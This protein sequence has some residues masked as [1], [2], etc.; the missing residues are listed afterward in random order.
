[1]SAGGV[2]SK[3]SGSAQSSGFTVSDAAST[4]SKVKASE[5]AAAAEGAKADGNFEFSAQTGGVDAGSA[6]ADGFSRKLI[7]HANVTMEVSDYSKAQTSVNNIIHLSGGYILQ[8][9]DQ[10]SASE[11]GGTYTIKIPASGFQTFLG[12]LEKLKHTQF[13]RSMKG[14]DVTEEYVDLDSRLKARKVVEARLLAFMDK[15]TRADDLLKFSNQL[16]DVQMEIE[17]IKGR[18]RYLDQNVAF[19]TIEL[20]LYQITGLTSS[21][22]KE[23]TAFLERTLNAMKASSTFIY[24]FVQG[25][26]VVAAG[27][28]PILVLLLA[29]GTPAYIVYR[30]KRVKLSQAMPVTV[31][32][33]ESKPEERPD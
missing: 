23:K 7:Y 13:E 3:L 28:L 25:V 5:S 18:M 27:A 12:Q 8:F 1:M 33:G 31:P 14:T 29:V 16:G 32:A 10:K 15:A 4:T 22:A 17:Q 9:S 21:A 30:K 6:D 24:E 2:D 11:L 20:R 26:V 19:S